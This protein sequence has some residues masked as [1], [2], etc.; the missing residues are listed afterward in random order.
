[1][2]L[3]RQFTVRVLA[4][5]G[6]Y[7]RRRGE[8]SADAV[9]ANHAPEGPGVGCADRFAFIQDRRNAVEEWTVD[10]I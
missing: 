9:L 8:H 6:T 5:D 10:D 4:A 2:V 7:G 1:M 3:G